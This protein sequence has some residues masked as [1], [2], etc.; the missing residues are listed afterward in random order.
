MAEL[1]LDRLERGIAYR[2]ASVFGS[3]VMLCPNC[4]RKLRKDHKSVFKCDNSVFF[5]EL[6]FMPE[7]LKECYICDVCKTTTAKSLEEC[8]VY[9]RR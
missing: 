6:E 5:E 9:E 3:S 1:N 7:G 2:K 4:I 8:V